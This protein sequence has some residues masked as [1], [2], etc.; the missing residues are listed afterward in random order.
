MKW[1]NLYQS[2]FLLLLCDAV[3]TAQVG[4][5]KLLLRSGSFTPDKNISGNGK[6]ATLRTSGIGKTFVVIQFE[7]IPTQEERS[8]L[9]KEGIELLDYIPNYAYTATI[10]NQNSQNILARMKGRSIIELS[11]EQKMEPGLANGRIPVHAVKSPGTVNVWINY[12]R[13]FSFE[14][15]RD[16]LRALNFEMISEQYKDYQVVALRVPTERLKELAAQP[17]VQY[18]QAVPQDDKGLNNKSTSNA[19]ANILHSSLPG[20][21]NLTGQ[22]VVVGV[23]DDANPLQHIDINGRII[24]RNSTEIGTHGVHVMG[25]LG[26]AGIMNERFSGYAP[27]ATIVAQSFSNIL[28]YSPQYVQDFGMVITNNSYGGDVN[29][30]ETFGVYDLYSQILDQQAFQLTSL[31]HV[32]AAGNSG[33][34]NCGPYPAGFANVLSGYQTA[35]NVISVGS[36]SETSVIATASSKG[37]ARDGRI[38]PEITAQGVSVMSTIPVNL[39]GGGTGTSMSSPA[40][41]GG[42]A[43]LYERYRQLHGNGNPKSG[44]MKALICNGATD[45]GNDGPDYK[46]GFGWMNLLRSVKMLET[47][48]YISDVVSNQGQKDHTIAIP[49]NTAQLKVMLY[50]NDP[51]GGILSSQ[52]LVHNL[53]LQVRNPSSAKILPRLLDPTPSKVNDIATTG[54]DNVNNI[55]Q[56]VIN[57]PVEGNYKISVLGTLIAQNPDQEYFIVY[58]I[59]PNSLTLTYP[60]GNEHLKDSDVINI[61]WDAF[62]NTTSTFT[63]QYRL[64]NNNP[65]TTIG[66]NL[67]AGTS[68]LA[69]TIPAGTTSDSVKVKVM[70]NSTGVESVS[71]IFTVAGIPTVTLS[72]LQCE[73]YISVDWTA[74]AGA[75]DYEV[76][77]L[78]GNEMVSAGITAGNNFVMGGLSKDSTYLLSV[79]ARLNGH[80]GRRALAISRKPDSGTC[81]GTISDKDL[82]IESILTPTG[83]G[84]TNTSSQLSNAIFVKIRIKNLDDVDSNEP[85]DVGFEL[86]GNPIPIETITPFIEKGKTYDHTFSVGADMLNV[87]DYKLKVYIHKSNDPVTKNDTIVKT[88]RQLPNAPISLPFLDDMEYLPVQT[89][90]SNQIGLQGDGRYDFSANTDAG[91]I[92]TFVNTGLANSGQRALTLDAN[93]YFSGGNTNF[94]DATFNLSGYNIDDSDI[95]LNFSYKNHGQ[96]SNANNKVWVRGKDTDPWIEAYDLFANQKIA[97]EG[98]KTPSGIEI[99]SLL[100][101]NNKNF[102]SSFQV[103][104][105]Q[106]GRMITADYTAG[107]GYSFDDIKLFTV[108]DDIQMLSLLQPAAANCGLGNSESI[109]VQIRNS[110]ARDITNVPVNYQIGNGPVIQ[111]T[112]AAISKRTT[113]SYTFVNKA[114][115]SALGSREIKVWAALVTDSYHDNDSVYLELYNAPVISTFPYLENFETNNGFWYAKG[116]NSSWQYGTPVSAVIKTAASGNKIWKTNLAGTHNDKE[117]SYLYSPC[118]EVAGLAAPTLSFSV[119]LDLEVCDPTP[120]DIVYVEYSGNGGA[121]TRLGAAGQGTNWYNKT[122]SGSGAWSIQDYVRWHVASIPLPTGFANLKVRFVMISD[123]FTRREGVALD[124]IH[125]YDKA[126]IIYDESTMALPVTQN[127]NGGTNW[128]HFTQNGKLVA[129]IYPNNQNLGNTAVQTYINTSGSRNV[130]SEYYLNRNFTIKPT[131]IN[132]ADSATVRLYFLETESEALI[133]AVGCANCGKPETAYELGVSKYRHSD[134]N[135]EDGSISNS[136]EGGWSFHPASQI[137]IV[138]YDKGYFTEF[139]VK[140]FSEF[141]LSEKFVG[142]SGA[143]PVELVSFNA[144]KKPG[145]DAGKDVLL[146]W[147]TTSEENFDHFDIEVA[148]GNEAYRL[149]DFAKIGAVDGNGGLKTGSNYAFTDHDNLKSGARYYR[150]KMIDIDSTY[151]YS[152]VRP[153]VFEEQKEWNVYPNPSTGVFYITYQANIGGEISLNVYDLN[154]RVF[155]STK[156]MATGFLQKQKIDLSGSQFVQGKYVLEVVNGKD[157]QVFQML[158]D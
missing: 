38:K 136:T 72:S 152:R 112:I 147:E 155:Q 17:F 39:Y 75:T 70:Q 64:K 62:G 23:G 24:N 118:F 78:K 108:T 14:E 54:V 48:S 65:W 7:A 123:A 156:S 61:N 127:V 150:L 146:E 74:V 16:G 126:S 113:I 115:L 47:Q 120:C 96:K 27:K 143:L 43:L 100:S 139:K 67:A 94:L 11:P 42:L 130:N 119:V 90:I 116:T 158:K 154:G 31:Q 51:A 122:Y 56:V 148:A 3:V 5:Y 40:V 13:T 10:A 49:A 52:N 22:G 104:M 129:S 69:W 29:N 66:N 79:R 128:V 87:G 110:S 131:N 6:G 98:Y 25:T 41:A 80:P 28:A 77:I 46:Y 141:W 85:L 68:Q 137:H 15:I 105:G 142:N 35:K 157:K 58:D 73:G 55:E 149:T 8:Q 33:T 133:A 138:P 30:C 132:L 89:V 1:K 18:V 151:A 45:K 59:I 97:Q 125:I 32:F 2:I 84:R 50:W 81:A 109:V 144:R 103:R 101:A 92:R 82:K 37:P 134:V 76:M 95:R 145:E 117:E 53:D 107:A 34:S 71:E 121:W 140:N 153:V 102:S 114:D 12:P 91:R 9:K 4:D 21:R 60:I 93:R 57:N 106:W 83:T 86:N 26:G 20:G 19:R 135:K 63:V 111:E 36:G 44:L 88:F 99:S 124:D